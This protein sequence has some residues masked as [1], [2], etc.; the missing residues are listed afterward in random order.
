MKKIVITLSIFAALSLSVSAQNM[1]SLFIPIDPEAASLAVS[2]AAREATAFATADNASAMSFSQSKF[3]GGVSYGMWAPDAA[4]SK[5]VNAGAF[6][7]LGEK[8][9]VG[10]T[11]S[12]ISDR[13][14]SITSATG[15]V[16]G[17]FT[18][19][20]IVARVGFS[21]RF[22]DFLSA[23]VT[24]KVLS[25]SIGPDLSGTAFGGDISAMYSSNGL[26]ATLALCNLGTAIK[27]GS[28]SYSMPMYAKAGAAYSI[29][30]LTVSAEA[31]YILEGAFNA[32]LGAEYNIADIAFLR[33]GYHYGAEDKGLPSFASVGLG[34]KYIGIEFNAAYLL[35][36]ETLGGT[37]MFGLG[38]SF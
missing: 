36:S 5:A 37:L 15:A 18:P 20:D 24:A 10:F 11:G 30:G 12:Y 28:E 3:R 25:S 38:Y 22:T 33:A 32:A 23:G 34:L 14:M 8:A 4:D 7:R 1:P 26:N 13:Q 19:K 27:Y 6:L 21:Y 9:A 16:T 2:S 17:T 31:D 29:V 35:A